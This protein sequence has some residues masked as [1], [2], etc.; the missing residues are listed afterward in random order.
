M[1]IHFGADM[2]DYSNQGEVDRLTNN[3]GAPKFIG[4]YLPVY[5]IT[6]DEV[7]Y[8]HDRG[9]GICAVDNEDQNGSQMGGN[10]DAGYAHGQRASDAWGNIGAHPGVAIYLDVEQSFYVSPNYLAGW[11]DACH[12]RGFQGGCYINSIAG[13]GHNESYAAARRMTTSPIPIFGSEPQPYNIANQVANYWGP[14][15]PDGYYDDVVIWQYCINY[16]PSDLD[17]ATDRGMA[18]MWG[19]KPVVPRTTLM[20]DASLKPMPNHFCRARANLAKGAV[21]TFDNPDGT[22]LHAVTPHW[23]MVKVLQGTHRNKKDA[24]GLQGWLLRSSLMTTFE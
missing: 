3:L 16:G 17:L 18:L 5:A 2:A 10:Y 13:N 19:A 9:I 20:Q 11:A 23:A 7:T 1:T 14:E 21:V 15:A 6:Q 24:K 22:P 12:A 4:R 8:L